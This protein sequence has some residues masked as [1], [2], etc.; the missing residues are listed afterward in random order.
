MSAAVLQIRACAVQRRGGPGGF[1]AGDVDA[2]WHRADP[3]FQ[4][5]F[6][7]PGKVV[8]IGVQRH[9][10]LSR[11][12]ADGV[13]FEFLADLRDR[14][15]HHGENVRKEEVPSAINQDLPGDLEESRSGGII[16]TQDLQ[17]IVHRSTRKQDQLPADPPI[18]DMERLEP[19]HAELR[20]LG[21]FT[22]CPNQVASFTKEWRSLASVLI[23]REGLPLPGHRRGGRH[24]LDRVCRA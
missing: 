6:D 4:P 18:L 5:R 15:V 17:E 7:L 14:L 12:S 23:C 21:H 10:L 20:I 16:R 2:S 24:I 19:V 8:R 3:R 9:L 13:R 1:L 22:R 11:R